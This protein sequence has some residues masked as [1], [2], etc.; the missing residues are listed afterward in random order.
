MIDLDRAALGSKCRELQ[1][2][3]PLGINPRLRRFVSH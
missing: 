2:N 1:M 3:E